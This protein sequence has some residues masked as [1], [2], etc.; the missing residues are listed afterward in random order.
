MNQI[1]HYRGKLRC[2]DYSVCNRNTHNWIVV[3][4]FS[5]VV[6]FMIASSVCRRGLLLWYTLRY[7]LC[8]SKQHL[9]HTC[10]QNGR[11]VLQYLSLRRNNSAVEQARHDNGFMLQLVELHHEDHL[12]NNTNNNNNMDNDVE[13]EQPRDNPLI[14]N[15]NNDLLEDEA[16]ELVPIESSIPTT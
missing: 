6:S 4:C 11:A 1:M 16:I 9:L 13:D 12:H 7:H 10:S 5:L 8:P 2:N 15:V 3:G 14:V